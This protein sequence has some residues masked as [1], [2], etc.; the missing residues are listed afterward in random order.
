MPWSMPWSGVTPT[1]GGESGSGE[2]PSLPRHNRRDVVDL[3][4]PIEQVLP[5]ESGNRRRLSAGIE[6]RLADWERED[7]DV[8]QSCQTVAFLQT[9]ISPS[10]QIGQ[11]TT[12]RPPTRSTADSARI[13]TWDA[14]QPQVRST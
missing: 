12:A 4:M 3:L 2:G 9:G 8:Q 5:V 6:G 10:P 14:H 11:R 13:V 7:A 1:T